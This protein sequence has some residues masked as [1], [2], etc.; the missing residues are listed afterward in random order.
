MTTSRKTIVGMASQARPGLMCSRSSRPGR[1][2][3]A[4]EATVTERLLAR[5]RRLDFL[6]GERDLVLVR[7]PALDVDSGAAE[8][9]RVADVQLLRELLVFDLARLDRRVGV[10]VVE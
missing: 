1:W 9:V 7:H 10:A 2:I 4:S 8:G 6:P 3:A 5:S